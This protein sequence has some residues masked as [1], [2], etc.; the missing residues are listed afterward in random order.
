M[1]SVKQDYQLRD[2]G[3]G[4]FSK[5]HFKKWYKHGHLGLCDFGLLNSNTAC[6]MGCEIMALCGVLIWYPLNKWKFGAILSE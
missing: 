5:A 1:D 2:H 6:N 4:L 3:D